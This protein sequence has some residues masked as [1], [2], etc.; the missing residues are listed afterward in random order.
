[1]LR[2]SLRGSHT[3]FGGDG[4]NGDEGHSVVVQTDG[5]LVVGGSTTN[6]D[7]TAANYRW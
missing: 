6:S 3:F 7:D 4:L 5:K 1:M 2:A